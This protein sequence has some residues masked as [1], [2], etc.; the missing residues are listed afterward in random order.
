MKE[1]LATALEPVLRD[2]SG[3]C[4]VRPRVVEEVH[5]GEAC[6]ML[7][8]PDGSGVG[9]G[10]WPGGDD[11]ERVARVA[12]QVQDWAVEALWAA[13]RPAVWPEC[14]AH[15]GSHPLRAGVRGGVAVWSCPRTG[16]AA[17]LVGELAAALGGGESEGG[18]RGPRRKRKRRGAG[19]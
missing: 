16:E 13:A 7:Y 12:D 14:P 4:A 6:V 2:L 19:E 3:S 18:E 17:A 5:D 15:P 1:E 11:A 8:E 9:I 10:V